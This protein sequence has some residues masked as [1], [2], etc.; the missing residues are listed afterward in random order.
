MDITSIS[1]SK[2]CSK[3][4]SSFLDSCTKRVNQKYEAF[5][6]VEKIY[7]LGE[8]YFYSKFIDRT[9]IKFLIYHLNHFKLNKI[10]EENYYKEGHKDVDSVSQWEACKKQSNN[11]LD[12]IK[13]SV[14]SSYYS[15]CLEASFKVVIIQRKFRAHLIRLI[16][17]MEK[18]N[19]QLEIESREAEA[20][21]KA[22]AMEK[23]NK[24]KN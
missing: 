15:Y 9:Q 21:V 22:K 24:K 10:A 2:E 17:K 23:I 14:S 18:M 11:F 8:K 13:K 6:K 7:K 3:D 19:E 4:A 20:R 16:Q 5:T 12:S 1:I